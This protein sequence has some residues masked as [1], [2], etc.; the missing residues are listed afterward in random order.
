MM[1]E[2]AEC[3]ETGEVSV[4]EL[5]KLLNVDDLAMD[6]T[7][8]HQSDNIIANSKKRSLA[9][10]DE[11]EAEAVTKKRR[12]RPAKPSTSVHHKPRSIAKGAVKGTV[13]MD[14]RTAVDAST[15]TE[16]SHDQVIGWGDTQ[17]DDPDNTVNTALSSTIMS[18]IEALIMPVSSHVNLLQKE[19]D[20]M[21]TAVT[22]LTSAITAFTRSDIN[23]SSATASTSDVGSDNEQDTDFIPASTASRRAKRRSRRHDNDQ[24]P[25]NDHKTSHPGTS[26]EPQEDLRRDVVASM[27]VDME[28][29]QRRA[30]NIIVSGVPYSSDDFSYVTNLIAEEFDLHYI[31]TVM[32]RR[33]GR[34]TDGRIQPLLVTLESSEDAAYFVANARLLR[35]SHDQ[36]VR[37]HVYIS[38][39]LTPAEAKAAYE[40]R[41]RRRL[42]NSQNLQSD[43]T[44]GAR[45]D[46]AGRH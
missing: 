10:D 31:P 39:D 15:Q 43:Q 22:Q 27:Y 33:I 26:A 24:R 4:E 29:K 35:R 37:Q 14:S 11:S 23:I 28:L 19:M 38:A 7:V 34:Q 42:K 30:R 44:V 20:D 9:N 6:A 25:P 32:C 40:I 3:A 46:D 5:S 36:L 13:K 21:K 1:S 45:N 17:A 18:C 8:V 16:S 2:L 41:C 12:G